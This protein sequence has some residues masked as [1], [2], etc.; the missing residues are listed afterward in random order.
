MKITQ[1]SKVRLLKVC[2]LCEMFMSHY[3]IRDYGTVI[4]LLNKI[5]LEYI[6]ICESEVK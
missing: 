5:A 1:G 3:E 6:K 4:N 2:R